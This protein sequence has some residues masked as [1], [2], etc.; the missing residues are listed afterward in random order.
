[1]QT[2]NFRVSVVSDTDTVEICGALKV[3]P[4]AAIT[5]ILTSVMIWETDI[6]F[7][8]FSLGSYFNFINYFIYLVVK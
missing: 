7:C 4:L 1:M 5:Y 2:D 3:C 8:L 6:G